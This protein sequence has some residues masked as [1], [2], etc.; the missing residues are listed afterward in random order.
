MGVFLA[1]QHG[2]GKFYWETSNNSLLQ[3][4]S[5]GLA[6]E[7]AK[8]RGKVGFSKKLAVRKFVDVYVRF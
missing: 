7:V 5:R 8:K 2:S 1:L 4:K 6:S 3:R